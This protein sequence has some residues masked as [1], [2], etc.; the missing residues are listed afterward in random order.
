MGSEASREHWDADSIPGLAQRVK[1]LAALPQLWLRL[2]LWF[3]SDPW[4]GNSFIPRGSQKTK[5]QKQKLREHEQIPS[6][7]SRAVDP[8]VGQ[9]GGSGHLWESWAPA[10]VIPIIP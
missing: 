1:D 2:Q 5:K 10:T 8:V 6:M 9:V 3:G 7:I 4:P